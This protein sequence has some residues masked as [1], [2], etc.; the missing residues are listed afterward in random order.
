MGRE[1][2]GGEEEKLP[3]GFFIREVELPG[4]SQAAHGGFGRQGELV[5]GEVFGGETEGRFQG[6]GPGVEALPRQTIDEVQAQVGEAGGPDQGQ[7]LHRLGRG[8][9]ALE[10]AQFGLVKGLDP[11]AQ[12]VD[13][14]VAE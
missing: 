7:G 6:V 12:A 13:A 9:A 4:G 5:T 2:V 14:Q 11:E 10:K 8:V 3:L 1:E